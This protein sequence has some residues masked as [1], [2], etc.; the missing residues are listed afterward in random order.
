MNNVLKIL[1]VLSLV[2]CLSTGLWGQADSEEVS[3]D[4]ELRFFML[5][6][7]FRDTVV[8]LT[9]TGR[10]R[11][12]AAVST[13]TAEDIRV[14]GARSLNELLEMYVPGLQWIAHNAN[15]SHVGVRGIISDRDDKYLLLINGRTMNQRTVVG[16]FTE[17]D[18]VLLAEI[19]HIDLI[20]GPGSATLGLGA[21]S[22]VINVITYSP[23]TFDGFESRTRVGVIEQFYSQEFKYGQM[24][25]GDIGMFLYGGV[26]YYIGANNDFAPYRADRGFVSLWGHSINAGETIPI[27]NNDKAQYRN[28]PPM[29]IHSQFKIYNGEIWARY[30][31]GGEVPPIPYSFLTD[32]TYGGSASTIVYDPAKP[33]DPWSIGYAQ[34]TVLGKYLFEFTGNLRMDALVS[35]DMTDYERDIAVFINIPGSI[36]GPL[37]QSHREDKYLGRLVL[38][39]ESPGKDHKVA[40]GGE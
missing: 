19:H 14:S 28:L 32:S 2:F 21:V 17:R 23:E 10:K 35:Y 7:S 26:S 25:T 9:S 22:M 36:D 29:K 40:L 27:P 31:T 3:G 8:T 39:W 12:P 16:Q 1:M 4:R 6:E 18:L 33:Y 5:E 11:I 15:V 37:I 13:I 30:T 20:R 34:F 24:F 38:N